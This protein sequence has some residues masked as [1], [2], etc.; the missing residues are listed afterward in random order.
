MIRMGIVM[1]WFNSYLKLLNVNDR[2]GDKITYISSLTGL[3]LYWFY[4]PRV[5]PF[6][7]RKSWH[8][9]GGTLKIS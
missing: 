7:G 1:H 3:T 5:K 6:A 4:I 8:L 9:V 2:G